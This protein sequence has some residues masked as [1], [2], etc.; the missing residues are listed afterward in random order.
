VVVDVVVAGSVTGGA[1]ISVPVVGKSVTRGSVVVF[2]VVVVVITGSVIGGKI[3]SVPA[4]GE[5]ESVT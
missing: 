1:T 5:G 2:V 4:V 3:I